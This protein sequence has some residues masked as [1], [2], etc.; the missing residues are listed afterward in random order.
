MF[1][2][3][4]FVSKEWSKP[5]DE[6]IDNAIQTSPIDTRRRLYSNIVLSGGSTLVKG[7]ETRLQK[8]IQRRVQDRLEKYMK[9]SNT[10][11]QPI[12]VNV[13]ENMAQRFA[14]WFGGSF[15]ATNVKILRTHSIAQL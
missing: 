10:P 13:L 2:H 8:S 4:E 1:F 12:T 3:P 5:L 14:V 7:F 15:L 6:V 9:I 11:I